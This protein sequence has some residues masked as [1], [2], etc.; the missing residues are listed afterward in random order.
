M[1]FSLGVLIVVIA[2]LVTAYV[3]K[4]AKEKG[5]DFEARKIRFAAV[6]FTGIMVL[7][8]FTAILAFADPSDSTT[9]KGMAIF[10]KTLTSLS[11]IAGGIIGYLFSAK[12]K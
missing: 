12:R 1:Y 5:V 3:V 8:L 10:E 11:P 2:I 6:T 7:V 9:G 4:N